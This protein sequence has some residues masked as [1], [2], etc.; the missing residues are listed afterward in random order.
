MINPCKVC[1]KEVNVDEQ[2]VCNDCWLS[3]DE[4]GAEVLYELERFDNRRGSSSFINDLNNIRMQR[5]E[6]GD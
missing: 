5:T 3:L 4:E 6:K 2:S 1:E